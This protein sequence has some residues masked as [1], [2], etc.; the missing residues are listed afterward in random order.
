MRNS[1]QVVLYTPAAHP[2]LPHLPLLVRYKPP[3]VAQF[4]GVGGIRTA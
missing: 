3:A 2:F 1:E 4:I